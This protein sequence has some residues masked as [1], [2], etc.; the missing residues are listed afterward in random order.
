MRFFKLL[1]KKEDIFKYFKIQKKSLGEN[2][3]MLFFMIECRRLILKKTFGLIDLNRTQEM[4]S[5]Q[6]D[7]NLLIEKNFYYKNYT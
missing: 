5:I 6:Y 2:S 7:F 4:N 3:F 1:Y